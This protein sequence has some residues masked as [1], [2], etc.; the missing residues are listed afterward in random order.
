MN[1]KFRVIISCVVLALI[2]GCGSVSEEKADIEEA[3]LAGI[4]PEWITEEP[5][6]PVSGGFVLS[7]DGETITSEE[8][9][10]EAAKPL[11]LISPSNSYPEFAQQ[12]GPVIKQILDN[13]MAD[14]LLYQEAKKNIPE[15]LSD[16]VLDNFVEQE[17]QKYISTFGGNYAEAQANLKK[18]GFED[19][20]S[21][22]RAKKKQI[23][24]E[25]YISGQ[26]SEKYPITHSELL[27]HYNRMKDEHFAVEGFVEFRLVDIDIERLIDTNEIDVEQAKARA[28]KLAKEI[29]EALNS[30]K[31]FAKLAKAHSHGDRASYGGL[32]ERVHP[33]SLAEPYDVMEKAAMQLQP[34]QISEP[35]EAGGHIFIVKLEQKQFDE[36][37]P[38]EKVQQRIENILVFEQRKK[39]V[40]ELFAKLVSQADIKNTD[41]F[42]DYCLEKVYQQQ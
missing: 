4:E 1:D 27:N 41:E 11:K 22:Y 26:T 30:G 13:K 42:T 16:E 12:M 23:L 20:K 33:P 9:M 31:D 39:L 2:I 36:K 5:I 15:N 25:M 3:V 29:I 32:W 14:I 38:F 21:F 17:V 19:W 35:I 6:L 8:V 18:S 10:S 7:I 34:G 40:N 37:E 28:E 24:I